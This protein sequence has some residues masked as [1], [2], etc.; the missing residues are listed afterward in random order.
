M[1]DA[2]NDAASGA[3]WGEVERAARYQLEPEKEAAG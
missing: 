1:A 2:Y 3:F